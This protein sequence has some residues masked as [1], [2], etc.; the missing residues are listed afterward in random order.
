VSTA[1][2]LH[3]PA[4]IVESAVE[5][6]A[7]LDRN[8]LALDDR[9]PEPAQAD[10]LAEELRRVSAL[11]T[12]D[13]AELLARAAE[14]SS[15]AHWKTSDG[16]DLRTLAVELL[17]DMGHPFALAVPPDAL[18]AVR[19]KPGGKKRRKLARACAVVGALC[20]GVAFGISGNG[21]GLVAV[22]IL[23][24]MTALAIWRAE[25][26]AGSDRRAAYALLF[27]MAV[28][29]AG[30]GFG[31]RDALLASSSE[32]GTVLFALSAVFYA[33]APRNAPR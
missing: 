31:D 3:A 20:T 29:N 8:L 26:P 17:V 7:E 11:R 1:V 18:E 10:R 30:F 5:P 33:L 14:K 28:V 4:P 15:L 25:L 2:Q 16:L 24:V 22:P 23:A 12:R 9:L 21:A 13:A 6:L 19:K 27:T 32:V